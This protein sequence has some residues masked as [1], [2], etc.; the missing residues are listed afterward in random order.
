M[1]CRRG[2]IRSLMEATMM[3]LTIADHHIRLKTVV[4]P[5]L[6][7]KADLLRVSKSKK[8]MAN[9]GAARE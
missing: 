5:M 6:K 3:R 8:E 7:V 2:D 4:Y 9:S 1:A